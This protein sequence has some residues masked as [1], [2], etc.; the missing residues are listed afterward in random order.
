MSESKGGKIRNGIKRIGY[1]YGIRFLN[2]KNMSH[3]TSFSEPLSTTNEVYEAAKKLLW[4]LWKDRRPI[5]LISISLTNLTKLNGCKQLSF[6]DKPSKQVE[7]IKKSDEKYVLLPGQRL[8]IFL[9][10]AGIASLACLA[11]LFDWTPVK[12]NYVYGVQ[13]RYFLPMLPLLM[14]L[15]KNKQ[16]EMKASMAKYIYAGL[17]VLQFLTI[18][19]IYTVIIGR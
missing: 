3:Q 7:T 14:M 6:F 10:I 4:E 8:W 12:S 18:Y 19:H 13:G 11:L 2:F 16:I 5:R 15:C 9:V 1:E 17:Y